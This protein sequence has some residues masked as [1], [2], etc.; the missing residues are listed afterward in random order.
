MWCK[1]EEMG[2]KNI[3]NVRGRSM[4]QRMSTVVGVDSLHGSIRSSKL[5]TMWARL[6]NSHLGIGTWAKDN[7]FLRRTELNRGA[8]ASGSK[9]SKEIYEK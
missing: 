7:G 9:I 2:T 8:L 4:A 5:Q 6:V 3:H 1:A